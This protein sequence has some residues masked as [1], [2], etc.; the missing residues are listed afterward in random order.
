MTAMTDDEQ[1][2]QLKSFVQRYGSPII[3]GVLLALCV[4]FG[5]QWWS[6][7]QDV[8]AS[9]LTIQYQNLLNQVDAAAQD[10]ATYKKLS[11][12]SNKLIAEQPDSAQAVQ[13]QLLLAK[14]AF[15]K[16]DYATANKLLTQAQNSKVKDEG[17]KAIVSLRLAYTQIAQNQ[18]DAALK[19]LD[20]VKIEAFTPSV[21]EARGDIFIAKKDT[22]S[23][24]KA[25][26]QAW[27]VLVKREQPRELLQIKLANLGILVE[28]PKIESPILTPT[29]PVSQ[30]ATSNPSES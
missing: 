27:D 10:E 19:T 6:K 3:T 16:Q 14:L 18:P 20:A 4:F 24:Q 17:L 21:A 29:Q 30:A 11:A 9:N 8:T 13:T 23:A 15:D 7:K 22:A 26:Q 28:D 1:K 2:E 12:D 5:W 25:Y